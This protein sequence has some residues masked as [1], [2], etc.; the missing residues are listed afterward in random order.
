MRTRLSLL[1][2]ALLLAAP[3]A[4]AQI[5]IYHGQEPP[6]DRT[7]L[8]TR[9]GDSTYVLRI[10]GGDTLG[11]ADMSQAVRLERPG[12]PTTIE[13]FCGEIR[14]SG[15]AVRLA[16]W[17]EDQ[18]SRLTS[19]AT[20]LPVI[21]SRPFLGRVGDSLSLF[22]ALRWYYPSPRTI[23][24]RTY[25]NPGTVSVAIDVVRISDGRR[26][27]LIDSLTLL[28]SPEPGRPRVVSEHPIVAVVG[29]RLDDAVTADSMVVR[30]TYHESGADAHELV[31]H[32]MLGI[33]LGRGIIEGHHDEWFEVTGDVPPRLPHGPHDL[34]DTMERMCIHPDAHDPL[35]LHVLIDDALMTEGRRLGIYTLE[36][37]WRGSPELSWSATAHRWTAAHR[38]DV[39]GQYF[40]VFLD[41]ESTIESRPILIE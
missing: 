7:E 27:A 9:I 36:G 34:C 1:A 12:R 16:G 29:A 24:P 22:R 5:A 18:M 31:R 13:I 21:T 17:M 20:T 15:S 30:F 33:G 2:F 11:A 38:F 6:E 14:H 32:D 28:A 26:V 25:Q 39:P 37:A 3:S 41:D 8:W 35:L 40:V 4:L 19:R 10:I 23:D